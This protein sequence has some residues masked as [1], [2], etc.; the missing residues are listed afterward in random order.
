[1]KLFKT[2]CVWWAI[3]KEVLRLMPSFISS[4]FYDTKAFVCRQ[5]L[6]K[7]DI[8]S[9]G[10]CIFYKNRQRIRFVSQGRQKVTRAPVHE[11][12]GSVRKENTS[13]LSAGRGKLS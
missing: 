8:D 6:R 13:D 4:F 11:W 2:A 1:M 9:K 7:Y 3:L 5:W 10:S 12:H